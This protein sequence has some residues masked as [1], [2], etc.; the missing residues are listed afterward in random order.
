MVNPENDIAKD[1]EQ[2]VKIVVQEDTLFKAFAND[3]KELRTAIENAKQQESAANI[4]RAFKNLGYIERAAERLAKHERH[5]REI[6]VNL[7]RRVKTTSAMSGTEALASLQNIDMMVTQIVT[8]IMTSDKKMREYLEHLQNNIKHHEFGAAKQLVV[9]L[10]SMAFDVYDWLNRMQMIDSKMTQEYTGRFV[11]RFIR[12]DLKSIEE[13][14]A[15]LTPERQID[16]LIEIIRQ[17]GRLPQL[18]KTVA[19][20]ADKADTPQL[21]LRVI[22]SLRYRQN[23]T[24]WRVAGTV[25]FK[26]GFYDAAKRCYEKM[27]TKEGW[28]L[29]ANSLLRDPLRVS[30]EAVLEKTWDYF[31]KGGMSDKKI[32]RLCGDYLKTER[33][34]IYAGLEYKRMR[35]REGFKLAGDMYMKAGDEGG[36][37]IKWYTEA[38][39]CYIEAGRKDL[40]D[41]AIDAC[42]SIYVEKGGLS[43]KW[44]IYWM[45]SGGVPEKKMLEAIERWAAKTR[46]WDTAANECRQLGTEEAINL[47]AKMYE[48]A[49]KD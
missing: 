1:I 46:Q 14:I 2:E 39:K 21:A 32:A 6:Q 44:F 4:K 19:L 37:S 47:A 20:L 28:R 25:F 23:P 26:K 24:M 27:E 3:I 7:E 8:T 49:G 5:A 41:L 34:W 36:D 22:N 15:S 43:L 11:E 29:A 33:F 45:K 42:I 18:N 35:T 30:I 10:E 16:Y 13:Y 12:P 38:Q 31:R 17:Q 40:Y 48:Q 9:E